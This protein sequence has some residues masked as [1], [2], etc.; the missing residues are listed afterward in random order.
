ML[1]ASTRGPNLS[2][3]QHTD[4][5][6]LEG[7]SAQQ[8]SDVEEVH[9]EVVRAKKHP[10]LMSLLW[11]SGRGPG[12]QTQA[13][14]LLEEEDERGQGRRRPLSAGSTPPPRQF[15]GARAGQRQAEKRRERPGKN[16]QL[17]RS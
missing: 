5:A 12:P 17:P 13:A 14:L 2:P 6:S 8:S 11:G 7:N 16:A 10:H 15:M 4:C 3:P 9:P 1:S